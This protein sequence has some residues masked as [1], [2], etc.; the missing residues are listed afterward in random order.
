MLFNSATFL[1]AF[2]P[3]VLIGYWILD[4]H[5]QKKVLTY[6]WLV[7]CS[8]FFYTWWNPIYLLLLA[9]SIVANYFLGAYIGRESSGS[10]KGVLIFGIA[11]NLAL[12]GYFKYANFFVDNLNSL[13]GSSIEL[14]HITLP[15]AISFFTFQQITYLVDAYRGETKDYNFLH[16]CL[17]VTFFPQ[18]IA[19]PIVH[20]GEMLP[21]FEEAK[22]GALNTKNM[23]I[24]ISIFAIGLF[25]K[26]VIAD[27]AAN[28]AT[29]VFTAAVRGTDVGFADA[30][31]G[32]LCY[33]FQLYFDFSG[34]SDMAIG[35]GRMFGIVIP[36]NFNSPY[37]ARN[38]AEFW[39]RWHITLSRFLRDYVYIALGGN[40]KGT[41]RR[42]TNLLITMLLGGL[43]HGAGWTFVLWG[44]LH[45]M[46]LVVY[47][48]WATILKSM[49]FDGRDAGWLRKAFGTGLTFLAVVV[50]WVFFRAENFSAG[51]SLLESMA[52]L[53]GVALP[54]TLF[55]H[56]GHLGE[57]LQSLGF[58]AGTA[59][60]VA[61]N[62]KVF[63]MVLFLLVIVFSAPN[64]QQIM[65]DYDPGL[66]TY[67]TQIP[68]S[69]LHVKWR[70]DA[71]W[72]IVI[73]ASLAVTLI[74]LF[75]GVESE[76]LYF[77]F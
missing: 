26:V 42:Y 55:Q 76:F 2:L 51:L 9:P 65:R 70:P 14:G 56:L 77:Q 35:L 74:C 25:K 62:P 21:Q 60:L 12:I 58:T 54:E 31:I 18:L 23:S 36:L 38:I 47:H 3:I 68:Q 57:S 64:T 52:G 15:L 75:V 66:L 59:F 73:G 63:A 16:Y 39:H 33:T 67:D 28:F 1:F 5:I 22:P 4:Q 61:D 34:Y 27:T 53:N 69:M 48:A 29:P 71:W 44:G 6:S 13:T 46:Y 17:F 45:G 40:R 24:G 43:W 8:F 37:K 20:H 32:V 11:A 10:R 30:W 50:G 72:A 19:G 41:A 7:L 49:G